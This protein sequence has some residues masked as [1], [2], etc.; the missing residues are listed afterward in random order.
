VFPSRLSQRDWNL[1]TSRLTSILLVYKGVQ[2]ELMV[3]ENVILLL[4]PDAHRTREIWVAY[5][6]HTGL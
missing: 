4:C 5:K 1:L 3:G 2:L 6:F